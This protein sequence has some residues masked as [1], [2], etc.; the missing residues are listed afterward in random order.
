MNP[1]EE[2]FMINS[3]LQVLWAYDLEFIFLG[4]GGQ[5]LPRPARVFFQLGQN[6]ERYSL[7]SDTNSRSTVHYIL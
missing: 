6:I 7:Q 1:Q 3:L 2:F 5:T 4:A